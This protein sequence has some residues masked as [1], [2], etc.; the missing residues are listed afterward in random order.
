MAKHPAWARRLLSHADL[1]AIAA[2]IASAEAATSGQIKVHLERRVHGGTG[3]A[4]AR[5]KEVF[6]HLGL[7]R[8]E[9]RDAVLIYLAL[10]DRKLAIIGDIGI[11]ERVGD[12]YWETIRDHLVHHLRTGA[13]RAAIVGADEELGRVLREHF[14]RSHGDRKDLCNEVSLE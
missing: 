9:G 1:D 5:A 8:T 4:L 6:A 3:D 14:P 13:P 12:A 7:H 2:A 11:H 10:E